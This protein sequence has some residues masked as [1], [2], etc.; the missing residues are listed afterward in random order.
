M[1]ERLAAGENATLRVLIFSQ[2]KGLNKV[3]FFVV[4]LGAGEKK[5][6]LFKVFFLNIKGIAT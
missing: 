4:T 1:V 5:S 3:L 2:T 6:A